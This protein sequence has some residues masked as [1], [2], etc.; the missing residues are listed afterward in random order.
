[1]AFKRNL[2]VSSGVGVVGALEI[3]GE[4][5]QLREGKFQQRELEPANPS[6][7]EER[8]LSVTYYIRLIIPDLS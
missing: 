6:L 5:E 1:M 4:N 8:I 7:G 3:L 2:R